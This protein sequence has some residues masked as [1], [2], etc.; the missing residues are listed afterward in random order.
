VT[1][2]NSPETFLFSVSGSHIFHRLSK[3]QRL[4]QLE[5][6]GKSQKISY[7]IGTRT[8]TRDHLSCSTVPQP[9]MLPYAHT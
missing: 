9:A 2:L 6:L 8:Q 3:P 1:Q 4:V 7:L 5:G